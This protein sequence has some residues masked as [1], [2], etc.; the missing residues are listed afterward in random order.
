MISMLLVLIILTAI[1][2]FAHENLNC[3]KNWDSLYTAFLRIKNFLG[4]EYDHFLTDKKCGFSLINSIK[5]NLTQFTDDKSRLAQSLLTR[6][7]MQKSVVTPSGKFRIH[8]DTTGVNAI[9]YSL[10]E[11]IKAVDS[12]YNFVCLRMGFPAPPSD[13]GN[14]G[15]ILYDFYI[16][17][18]YP[19][20]GYTEFETPLGNNRYTSFIVIDNSFHEDDYY[21]KG[22]DAARVTVVHE[23]HHAIQLG[24]YGF[25]ETDAWF[26]E[27]TST[28]ME[29]F[30]F[31][32]V[33]DYYFYL[34]DF[35]R[36][37]DKI[38]T[39]H[40]GYSQAIWN[41]Y[42]A[43]IFENDYSIFVHQ[44]ELMKNYPALECIKKSI[45][46]RGKS[47]RSVF[48]RF[49]LYNY[50][51]SWRAKPEEYYEE[52]RYYP[53]VYI[54]MKINFRIPERSITGNSQ[55]CAAQYIMIVDSVLNY[56]LPSDS[57]L[58]ILV[59]VNVDSALNW[60]NSSSAFQYNYKI[61]NS[62]SSSYK[63]ISKNLY[64][65]LEV[66]D[67]TNW[68][69]LYVVNDTSE[70]KIISS[71]K[72]NLA[73]PM[74]VNFSKGKSLRI[75]IPPDWKGTTQLLI[76]TSSLDVVYRSEKVIEFFEDKLIVS[77]DGKTNSKEIVA[78]GVYYFLLTYDNKKHI[79]KI[80]VLNE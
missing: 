45:E 42:L 50:Y 20:Y 49:F 54:R 5:L 75:P 51:T 24:N 57:I 55:P 65:K 78:S 70:V 41:I 68:L 7:V 40:N 59:N 69:E 30:V 13:F 67:P 39:A 15:D 76:L 60:S 64:G 14:G 4:S 32:S 80:V 18:V 34:S 19:L 29:E 77:W 43:K 66:N 74:P 58:L 61:T 26:Y 6:P 33:N 38:F 53:E 31:D 36:R 10:E 23:F 72:L 44:W 62:F 25:R 22:I 48:A 37:T 52:G 71:Q 8:F 21:T 47:F 27:L 79:G 9:Q 73:F 28:S 56:P 3:Q 12:S 1:N 63:K 35:F 16:M 2:L 46:S 17:N 11:L